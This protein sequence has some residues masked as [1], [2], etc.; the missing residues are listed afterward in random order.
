MVYTGI[1]AA[2]YSYWP[3]SQPVPQPFGSLQYDQAL[4]AG[5][6]W[7]SAQHSDSVHCIFLQEL[8]RIDS[9]A[10]CTTVVPAIFPCTALHSSLA[11]PAS[12]AQPCLLHLLSPLAGPG[13]DGFE[14]SGAEEQA[15]GGATY[16]SASNKCQQDV[17]AVHHGYCC[18]NSTAGR[19]PVPAPQMRPF[20]LFH[21][22]SEAE[23]FSIRL[24]LHLQFF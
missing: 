16:P 18:C 14:A 9:H 2:V 17:M 1:S 11:Q 10:S 19:L 4:Q 8:P 23:R 5:D 24:Q 12:S 21:L 7:H 13:H 20:T 3:G 15:H 6:S 22:A